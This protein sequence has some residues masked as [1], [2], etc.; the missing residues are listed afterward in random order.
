M[1]KI[2]YEADEVFNWEDLVVDDPETVKLRDFGCR[3]KNNYESKFKYAG[4]RCM[5]LSRFKLAKKIYKFRSEL[6]ETRGDIIAS[7]VRLVSDDVWERYFLVEDEHIRDKLTGRI[8]EMLETLINPVTKTGPD[9]NGI[10]IT[11]EDMRDLIMTLSGEQPNG[12]WKRTFSIRLSEVNLIND[13]FDLAQKE[14]LADEKSLNQL[15]HRIL[16]KRLTRLI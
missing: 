16:G 12:P 2:V 9:I 13:M 8:V 15:K 5:T 6:R 14:Q 4:S 10:L 1:T 11:M 7:R 3:R